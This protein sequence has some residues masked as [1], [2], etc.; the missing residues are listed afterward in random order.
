MPPGIPPGI[1][2]GKPPNPDEK[3]ILFV[4]YILIN[5]CLNSSLSVIQICSGAKEKRFNKSILEMQCRDQTSV[6]VFLR[7]FRFTSFA[8]TIWCGFCFRASRAWLWSFERKN[9]WFQSRSDSSHGEFFFE[10]RSLLWLDSRASRAVSRPKPKKS[11][12]TSRM[13]K[14]ESC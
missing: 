5:C 10:N 1:P 7:I 8:P 4:V 11:R 12:A 13:H 6:F 3:C 14:F 2:P 9:E